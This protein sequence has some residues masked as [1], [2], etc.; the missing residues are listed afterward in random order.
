MQNFFA[1]FK[2]KINPFVAPPTV[3]HTSHTRWAQ[4]MFLEKLAGGFWGKNEPSQ[5]VACQLIDQF[6][7][8]PH[9]GPAGFALIHLFFIHRR[10]R[11]KF[12]CRRY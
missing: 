11:T 4:Q 1:I 7:R 8:I 6:L 3:T 2:R 10:S 9:V 12:R 5:A